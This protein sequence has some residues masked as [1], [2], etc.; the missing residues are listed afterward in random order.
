MQH[1]SSPKT[2]TQ[3]ASEAAAVRRAQG[4]AS[5]AST[6]ATAQPL[7]VPDP[8]ANPETHNRSMAHSTP[9]V[10]DTRHLTLLH[11]PSLRGHILCEPKHSHEHPSS[12][13][14]KSP[15][16]KRSSQ[17]QSPWASHPAPAREPV[18][19]GQAV[20]KTQVPGPV[21]ATLQS[22]LCADCDKTQCHEEAMQQLAQGAG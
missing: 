8:H 14:Q 16:L 9:Q 6:Y 19:L 17:G 1:P 22:K 15:C 18:S 5:A 2:S 11:P 12:S 20:G 10:R 4:A 21:W 13:C 3:D 7:L